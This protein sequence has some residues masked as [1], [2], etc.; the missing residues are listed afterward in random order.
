MGWIKIDLDGKWGFIKGLEAGEQPVQHICVS[1]PWQ[2]AER[3][4]HDGGPDQ[5]NCGIK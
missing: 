2:S 3:D 1:A 5:E 4:G